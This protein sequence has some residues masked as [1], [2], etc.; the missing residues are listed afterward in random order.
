M[1][2]LYAY[3]PSAEFADAFRRC[4][5][6]RFEARQLVARAHAARHPDHPV[7][8]ARNPFGLDTHALGFADDVDD[9]PAGLS[10]A[11]TRTWL[12]PKRGKA[13][14]EWRAVLHRM[15]A[16]PSLDAVCERF[17]IE[18]GV[19]DVDRGRLWHLVPRELSDGRLVATCGAE[20]PASPHL[21]PMPLSEYYYAALEADQRAAGA[22]GD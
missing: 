6:Q 13:G 19:L 14:D 12:I 2:E 4:R 16:V 9:V 7:I 10:R 11:K 22:S 15:D 21:T 17:T 3:M 1:S 20:L 18:T 8:M 5:R